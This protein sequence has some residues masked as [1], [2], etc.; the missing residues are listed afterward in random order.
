MVK[1]LVCID[2]VI[3]G[4]I[5]KYNVMGGV[6]IPRR[7]SKDILDRYFLMGIVPPPCNGVMRF[8]TPPPM[9]EY[10]GGVQQGGRTILYYRK[11]K[12]PSI[13]EVA[14]G[15][16]VGYIWCPDL[17]INVMYWQRRLIWHNHGNMPV[18][19]YG[20]VLMDFGLLQF[21]IMDTSMMHWQRC[22]VCCAQAMREQFQIPQ[23]RTFLTASI[24]LT[25]L[26]M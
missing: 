15:N 5:L 2:Q 14:E 3:K 4:T 13:L 10:N 17:D 16:Y 9:G 8:C 1:T 22:F 12:T 11:S 7:V 19:Q 20:L 6:Q 26:F 25:W 23:G 21:Y 24:T 18:I